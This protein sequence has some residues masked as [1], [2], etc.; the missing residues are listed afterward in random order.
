MSTQLR[1]IAQ[2]PVPTPART[3]FFLAIE[4]LSGESMATGSELVHPM[5]SF[6]SIMTG[7]AFE[8]AFDPGSGSG[9]ATPSGSLLKD[10]GREVNVVGTDGQRLY[11]YRQVQ[12]VGGTGSEGVGGTAGTTGANPWNSDVFVRVWAA[13]GTL[14]NV[15]RTG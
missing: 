5:T 10:L 15:V 14:V 1:R 8:A 11:K 13:D 3:R 2:S 7:T 9:V 4:D 6:E 12:I